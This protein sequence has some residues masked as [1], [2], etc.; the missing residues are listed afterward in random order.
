[1]YL[2]QQFYFYGTGHETTFNNIRW[3]IVFHGLDGRSD[4]FVYRAITAFLLVLGTYSAY[5]FVFIFVLHL[6]ETNRK[7]LRKTQVEAQNI[8]YLCGLKMMILMSFKVFLDLIHM[9]FVLETNQFQ[10]LFLF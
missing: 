6:I 1:M 8:A 2:L 5:A 4:S 7:K 9:S 3:E 10:M